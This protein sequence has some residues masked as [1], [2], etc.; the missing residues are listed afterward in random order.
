MLI[1][2]FVV[3][4]NFPKKVLVRGV[5]P[6][7][8]G[9][10]VSGVLA[11]PLLRIWKR[12]TEIAANDNWMTDNAV[13]IDAAAMQVGAFPL[14]NLSRDAAILLTLV[15]GVYTA[16]VSGSGGTTGIALVEVYDVP[17]AP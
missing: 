2:G 5:G 4:G 10:G 14:D 8:A 13:A 15:Q 9:Q 12:S 7:L 17:E 11:D 6:T 16:Q 3:T 1:S